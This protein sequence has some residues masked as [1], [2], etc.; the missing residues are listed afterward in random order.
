MLVTGK[1]SVSKVVQIQD[2]TSDKVRT[3]LKKY[4]VQIGIDKE[5]VSKYFKL[6]KD[7]R[8]CILIFIRNPRKV[9]PF[10]IDKTGFGMQ[11]GWITLKSV[12][13]IRI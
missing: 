12:E 6:F 3:L 4:G 1:A 11:S 13:Y 10:G 9:K 2:L 5:E 7:K 8:Y